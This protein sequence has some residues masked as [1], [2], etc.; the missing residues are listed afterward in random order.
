MARRSIM[1][2]ISMT[3]AQK[4]KS[5]TWNTQKRKRSHDETI[6]EL[7]LKCSIII[8]P[9]WGYEKDRFLCVYIPQNATGTWTSCRCN[10]RL[11]PFHVFRKESPR[12]C[13]FFSRG[14]TEHLCGVRPGSHEATPLVPTPVSAEAAQDESL[15]TWSVRHVPGLRMEVGICGNS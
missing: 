4:G 1:S 12:F 15:N 5:Q 8:W 6:Q 7:V 13:W 14:S 11:N 10:D 3:F 9:A 2:Q